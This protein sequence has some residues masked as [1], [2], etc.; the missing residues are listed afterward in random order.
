MISIDFVYNEAVNHA[1][2]SKL[3]RCVTKSAYVSAHELLLTADISDTVW[4]AWDTKEACQHIM[5]PRYMCFILTHYNGYAQW[6]TVYIYFHIMSLNCYGSYPWMLLRCNGTVLN[7]E[8]CACVISQCMFLSINVNLCLL[9][10]FMLCN[11]WDRVKVTILEVIFTTTFLLFYSTFTEIS[12]KG[13][14]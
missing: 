9:V 2:I 4:T 6:Y 11:N 10:H 13:F 3:V 12:S 1:S 5:C 7:I 8:S 14:N